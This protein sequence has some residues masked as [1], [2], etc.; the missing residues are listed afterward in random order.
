MSSM[1]RDLHILEAAQGQFFN[2]SNSASFHATYLALTASSNNFVQN[3]AGCLRARIGIDDLISPSPE[4]KANTEKF[5]RLIMHGKILSGTEF[6]LLGTGGAELFSAFKEV[7]MT[8][9]AFLRGQSTLQVLSFACKLSDT[10]T[11]KNFFEE[12]EEQMRTWRREK[13]DIGRAAAVFEAMLLDLSIEF[14]NF[15][16]GHP[17][18][19]LMRPR[20]SSAVF[21]TPASKQRID[22]FEREP[23]HTQPAPVQPQLTQQQIAEAVAASVPSAVSACL[24]AMGHSQAMPLAT[25]ASAPSGKKAK[26]KAKKDPA[27]PQAAP[28][29][30]PAPAVPPGYP[31]GFPPGLPPAAPQAPNYNLVN[32]V[33]IIGGAPHDGAVTQAEMA[34]F[35]AA[36]KDANGKPRCFNFWRRGACRN[37]TCRFAHA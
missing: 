26:K 31:P 33:G 9:A 4:R 12:C 7:P 6:M 15:F 18:A 32:L 30:P 35:S 11:P 36:N 3:A 34:A 19:S 20:Y 13:R 17:S 28:L 24:Q 14:K 10:T 22:R 37:P 8:D 16:D 27:A 29:V 23:V 2:P 5:I 1:P 25:S 21:T